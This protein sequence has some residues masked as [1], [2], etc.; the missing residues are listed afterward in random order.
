MLVGMLIPWVANIIYV[1]NWNPFPQ[2]DLTPLALTLANLALSISFLRFRMLDIQPIAH[3]SVFNAMQDGV[4]VLD[5]KER[6]V[7]ANP[8]AS[9]IFQDKGNFIGSN[10]I[11]LFPDWKTWET[12]NLKGEIQQELKLILGG[13]TLNFSLRTTSIFD[14]RARR[15]GR[16]LLISDVTTQKR[17]EEELMSASRMKSQLLANLGHDLRSPLGAI[18]G[19]AEMLKDGSFGVMSTNQVK[20]SA[21]I[22]MKTPSPTD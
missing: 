5:Y 7:D 14:D 19:Y 21:E 22:P 18:I 10:I 2:L 17:A 20:A 1:T 11:S 3:D 15:D 13:E 16:V 9:L 6:I 8:V 12:I 4:I